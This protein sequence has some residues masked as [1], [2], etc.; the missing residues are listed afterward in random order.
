[1]SLRRRHSSHARTARCK[2]LGER[3]GAAS[4]KGERKL[5]ALKAAVVDE[6]VVTEECKIA[7]SSWDTPT[8]LSCYNEL[9][10][11]DPD[12]PAKLKHVF[13]EHPRDITVRPSLPQHPHHPHDSV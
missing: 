4:Q 1:V 11:L 6:A 3:K 10:C 7:P 8:D 5:G 13:H 2:I 9:S 12:T